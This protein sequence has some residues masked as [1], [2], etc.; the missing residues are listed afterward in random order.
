MRRKHLPLLPFP[1][2]CALA[3]ALLLLIGLAACSDES[4]ATPENGLT[5]ATPGT[6]AA[7]TRDATVQ[8]T[9]TLGRRPTESQ[10]TAQP[11]PTEVRQSVVGALPTLQALP[12]LE[13][14]SVSAGSNHT[15]GVL[16]DGSVL[17]WGD[18]YYGQATPPEGEFASVSVGGRHSCGVRRDGAVLCWGNDN[19][20]ETRPPEGE[21]TSV[22]VGTDHTAGAGRGRLVLCAA[23]ITGA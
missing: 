22:S 8:A 16:T 3:A 9:P 4:D 10:A 6:G 2:V 7:E 17:C 20:G 11:E 1:A 19:Y 5:Q 14:A 12:K 15:C 18:D 21:F 23:G 13:F